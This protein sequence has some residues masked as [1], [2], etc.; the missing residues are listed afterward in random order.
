MDSV[1]GH[2]MKTVLHFAQTLAL[3]IIRLFQPFSGEE[4]KSGEEM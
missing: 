2:K 3:R 1:N 4:H